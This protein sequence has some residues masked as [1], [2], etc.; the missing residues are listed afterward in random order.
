M[1]GNKAFMMNFG[2][3]V[4]IDQQIEKVIISKISCKL[5]RF[6]LLFVRYLH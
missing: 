3:F 4:M 1:Y 5:R 2:K 6:T